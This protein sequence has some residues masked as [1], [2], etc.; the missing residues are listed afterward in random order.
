[1]KWSRY[2]IFF[3]ASTGDFYLLYNT[4]SNFFAR[5]DIA[6]AKLLYKLQ[7]GELLANELDPDTLRDLTEKKVLVEN[8]DVE[9]AKFKLIKQYNRMNNKTLSLTIAPTLACNLHCS[10]CF[11]KKHPNIYMDDKVEDD[12]INFIAGHKD[13]E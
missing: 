8:D 7:D 4:M 2:N 13:I 9:M 10:Y 5:I 11:E 12:I 3:K 1:M 6:N